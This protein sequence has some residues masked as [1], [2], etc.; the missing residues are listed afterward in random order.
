M[1]PA[2]APKATEPAPISDPQKTIASQPPAQPGV[3]ANLVHW[4]ALFQEKKNARDPFGPLIAVAEI[5]P[6]S[7]PGENH[8]WIE[9]GS[10][11]LQAI[12]IE[13]RMAYIVLNQKVLTE[14]ETFGEFYIEK[15]AATEV[16]L[17]HPRGRK[18]LRLEFNGRAPVAPALPNQ[19]QSQSHEPPG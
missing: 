19:P 14:G 11:V 2:S 7:E 10:L 5:E 15:I 6:E 16:W 13:P 4:E 17:K 8:E 18:V 3:A 12:C 1:D 9:D